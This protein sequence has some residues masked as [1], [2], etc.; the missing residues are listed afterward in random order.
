MHAVGV[1]AAA[2]AAIHQLQIVD[3]DQCQFL[4]LGFEA[5]GFGADFSWGDGTGIV[6]INRRFGQA[7]DGIG[8]GMPL[9]G[10]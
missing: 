3:D 10:V 1:V 7:G 9:V 6:D 4:V 8:E 5:A 2:T